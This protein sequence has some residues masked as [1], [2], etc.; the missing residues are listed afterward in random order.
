MLP[1]SPSRNLGIFSTRVSKLLATGPLSLNQLPMERGGCPIC[2]CFGGLGKLSLDSEHSQFARLIA[3]HQRAVHAYI[4]AQVPRWSDADEIW[5]ETSVRLWLSFDKYEPGT[6]F[7][8]WA[9]RVAHFEVLTWRKKS[10]RSKV[11][12]SLKLV[13]ALES[14]QSQLSSESAEE[15]RLALDHCLQRCSKSQRDLLRKF[16]AGESSVQEIASQ[17]KRSSEAVYKS[18]QRTRQALRR[19]IELRL[20]DESVSS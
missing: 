4:F 12:F 17:L 15:R 11:V 7:V 6:N 10:S 19:C 1:F 2:G 20:S 16:Y 5:Q 3:Q 9:I 8:A 18:I 13:Q 14:E